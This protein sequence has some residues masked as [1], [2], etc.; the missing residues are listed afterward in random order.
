[1]RWTRYSL[2]LVAA[3]TTMLATGTAS[4]AVAKVAVVN[5]RLVYIGAGTTVNDLRIARH[6]GAFAVRDLTTPLLAGAGCTSVGAH[7]ATCAAAGIR[8]FS[9]DLGR[10]S[11]RAVVDNRLR[12]ATIVIR[13]GVGA[14]TLSSVA[15]RVIFY[16]GPGRDRLLGGPRADVILGKRGSDFIR[17]RGGADRL[18][19][20]PDDDL[21]VSGPGADRSFGRAGDD[22]IYGGLGND[23]LHGGADDDTMADFSGW[24]HLYGGTGEDYLNTFEL[25]PDGRPGDFLN[26]STGP[27]YGCRASPDDVLV[28]CDESAK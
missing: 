28:G 18:L 11:D 17:G 14:D 23:A 6:A 25:V 22:R 13:G 16:G 7:K 2:P 21:I 26:A 24:D 8:S 20:G 10:N 5:H 3:A 27:D 9:A 12:L 15:S 19:G 1:M 4:A